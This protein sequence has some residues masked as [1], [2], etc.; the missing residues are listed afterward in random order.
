MRSGDNSQEALD[1]V[2]DGTC[3]W[4]NECTGCKR[5]TYHVLPTLHELLVDHLAGIVLAGLDMDG[6]LY[7]RIRSA[8]EG[9]PCA[10]LCEL[11][12]RG[13]ERGQR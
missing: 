8:A 2:E 5:S 4:Q 1:T 9:L 6:L 12:H 13:V 11:S 10:I 7:D 3:P